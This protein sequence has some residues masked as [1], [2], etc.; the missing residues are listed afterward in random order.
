MAEKIAIEIDCPDCGGS[1]VY[2]GFAEPPFVGVV[3]LTCKGK[4]AKTV[5][6]TPF[7]VRKL[8][9]DIRTVRQ[10]RGSFIGTGVGP[11]G[12]EVTYEEFLNGKM[13]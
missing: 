10:S 4:G 7:T 12:G 9:E 6:I 13:P 1:G 11:T 8:R 3:C 5:F 2:H